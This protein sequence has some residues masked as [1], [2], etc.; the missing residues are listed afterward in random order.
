[1]KVVQKSIALLLVL[2]MLSSVISPV[3]A[4]NSG[5]CQIEQEKITGKERNKAIAKAFADKGVQRLRKEL[6]ETGFK[7][8]EIKASK[9]KLDGEVK[10]VVTVFLER[11]KDLAVLSYAGADNVFAGVVV[12]KRLTVIKYDP[13]SGQSNVIVILGLYELC[14]DLCK[15]ACFVGCDVGC[16][17]LCSGTGW[18]APICILV[19]C[20]LLCGY[21]AE[22]GCGP[23]CNWLCD[24]VT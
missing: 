1:M 18:F 22:Y 24:Q 9:I 14:V 3:M 5:I 17:S 16:S 8:K 6:I 10:I 7:L 21:I 11:G 13:I 23:G 19:V 2:V 20:P 15:Y 12:D 4:A